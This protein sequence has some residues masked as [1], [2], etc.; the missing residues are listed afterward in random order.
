[1]WPPFEVGGRTASA[2]ASVGVVAGAR[3]GRRAPRNLLREADVAMY[4]AKRAG[5][6]RLEVFAG[7]GPD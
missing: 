6:P 4:G 1:M 5:K 7:D 2:T 3:A